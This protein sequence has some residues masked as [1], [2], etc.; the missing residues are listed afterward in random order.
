MTDANTKYKHLFETDHIQADLKRKTVGGGIWTMLGQIGSYII[1]LGLTIVL[2]RL[3]TPEDYGLVAMVAVVTNFA[4]MFKDMGLSMAT[5]Q[6]DTI[7]HEQVSTLFWINLVASTIIGICLAG[8]APLIAMFYKEPRLIMVTIAMAITFP[9]GGLVLQHMAL[10]RRQM[11]YRTISL[12]QLVAAAV[13]TISGILSALAGMEYWSLVIMQLVNSLWLI[14]TIWLVCPW[15]PGRP[16][17]NIGVKSMMIFGG[18][19]T[20]FNFM[21]FFSRNADNLLIGKFI[22]TEQ[23]GVYDKAYQLLMLPLRQITYPISNVATAAL[24]RLQNDPEGY[25]RFYYKM[26]KAIA[27]TTMPIIA[28]M[29]VLSDQIIFIVL[30][31]QWNMA[32]PIFRILAFAAFIQ[33]IAATAGSI[34][35][36]TGQ[37]NRMLRWGVFSSVGTITSFLIGLPFG[38]KGVAIC[39]CI[40]TYILFIPCLKYAFAKSPIQINKIYELLIVPAAFSLMMYL[41]IYLIQYYYKPT[42]I[43]D[44]IVSAGLAIIISIFAFVTNRNFRTDIMSIYQLVRVKNKLAL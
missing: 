2:A 33:P 39:Y 13:S 17:K 3:L 24:S 25:R 35:I 37:T 8:A 40:F 41:S 16:R 9:L 1:R 44:V 15:I 14:V 4:M 32:G 42:A 30:G 12:L 23:L 43:I 22:G 27:Y 21:N 29:A 19:L 34:F 31:E 18:N 28:F 26:V 36:S 5:V 10:L 6:K 11:R 38:I 20:G 7:T